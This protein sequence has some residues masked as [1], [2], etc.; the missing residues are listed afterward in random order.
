[1]DEH[2]KYRLQNSIPMNIMKLCSRNPMIFP[3]GRLCFSLLLLSM[4][5]NGNFWSCKFSTKPQ[6]GCF[7]KGTHIY[8]GKFL[9]VVFGMVESESQ[10]APHH[11]I[12]PYKTSRSFVYFFFAEDESAIRMRKEWPKWKMKIKNV[13]EGRIICYAWKRAHCVK[14]KDFD[15]IVM[16]EINEEK[17]F[18]WCRCCE[19][20]ILKYSVFFFFFV[21]SK[22]LL[23]SAKANVILCCV[24]SRK[25]VLYVKFTQLTVFPVLHL[26]LSLLNALSLVPHFYITI[27]IYLFCPLRIFFFF[28]FFIVSI[29]YVPA[30]NE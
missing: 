28:I 6:A 18:D 13:S 8:I 1:M 27:F 22:S 19:R 12:Q 5:L 4:L 30:W 25:M 26:L 21:H 24:W 20:K 11:S 9:C 10:T 7:S 15:I 23:G 29:L 14:R 16:S 17:D 2:E 3:W